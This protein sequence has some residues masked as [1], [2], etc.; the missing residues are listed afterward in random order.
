M[1]RVY[2]LGGIL[3]VYTRGSM[4]LG[5]YRGYIGIMEKNMETTLVYW[6]YIG[7]RF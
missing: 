1:S 5:F 3:R 2:G 6:G 4:I 7:F